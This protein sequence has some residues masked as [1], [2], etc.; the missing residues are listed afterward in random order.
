MRRT[1]FLVATLFL[2]FSVTVADA[3]ARAD[4]YEGL[5]AYD[6]KD[7]AKAA[8]EWLK[9]AKK[10][11]KRSMYEAG[12]LYERG[13]GLRR[14]YIEA[15]FWY[16]KAHKA[17]SADGGLS[18]QLL[19]QKM[20]ARQLAAANDRLGIKTTAKPPPPKRVVRRNTVRT[21]RRTPKRRGKVSKGTKK[22][23]SGLRAKL[24]G[25]DIRF[26]GEDDMGDP[27]HF[28]WRL[29]AGGSISGTASVHGTAGGYDGG[30]YV[31]EKN[32]AGTWT[33]NGSILCIKWNKWWK[34]ATKCFSMVQ[35]DGNKWSM[36]SK[37]GKQLRV[38][39]AQR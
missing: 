22:P 20:S 26:T 16:K 5:R 17:G 39:I 38:Y 34:R 10:S 36:A 12:R 33:T 4:Y 25:A 24:A 6:A 15:Y 35:L 31:E 23:E 13:L 1:P 14:N 30:G 3:P 7:F 28:L 2:M 37:G 11:D 27:A 19:K 18:A 32:D 9:S 8:S 21:P 29:K